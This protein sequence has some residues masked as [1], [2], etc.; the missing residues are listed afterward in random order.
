MLPAP[1][2]PLLASPLPLPLRGLQMFFGN[3]LSEEGGRHYL[4]PAAIVEQPIGEF[5]RWRKLQAKQDAPVRQFLPALAG[6]SAPGSRRDLRG[7]SPLSGDA[8][9]R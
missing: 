2:F 4:H 8:H 1:R 7:A 3:L 9:S 5:R 6:M